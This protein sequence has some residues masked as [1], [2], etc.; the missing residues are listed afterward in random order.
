M[1]I[2]VKFVLIFHLIFC[3]L[4]VIFNSM[5]LIN[6]NDM[7]LKP[8]CEILENKKNESLKKKAVVFAMVI[9]FSAVI[10]FDFLLFNALRTVSNEIIINLDIA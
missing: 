2:G 3:V 8:T 10:I 7:N 6:D 1:E 9:L 5:L 4:A